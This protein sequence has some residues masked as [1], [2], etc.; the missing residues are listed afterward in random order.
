MA[1]DRLMV[2]VSGVRG[3]IGTTLTPEVACAF[4][5]AFGTML[6]PGSK[7][8][9]A[10]DSRPSGQ[11]VRA[12]LAAGLTGCGVSVI[13]LGVVTTP[14]AALMT[15]QLGCEGGIVVTASHNPAQYNGFK[16]L[17][18]TGPCLRAPDAQRLADIWRAGQFHTVPSQDC[19]S[20]I[21]NA[22]TH[23]QH[24]AAVC[25]ILDVPAIAKRRFKV[26]LDSINGAGC[27]GTPR[28][29]EAL[30]AELIHLNGQATGY[31]A[32]TPE[33]IAENLTGLC[34]AVREHGADVG[35]A[36][37][38]D[39][40]RLVVVDEKGQ[41]IG[42]EYT[43]AMT[44][45]WTLTHRKGDLATNLATS[46]MIDDIASRHGVRVHRS[47]TG[48]ANVVALMEARNC[49]FGGEGNGGVIDPRVVC[50]R[51]SFTGIGMI[52]AHLAE[53]GKPLSA[54]V[55]D[56]PAYA[57]IKTKMP[58]PLAAVPAILAAARDTYAD[59]PDATINDADG[60]RIDLPGQWVA[61]RA[62]NTEPIIRIF[63]ESARAE[64]ARKL[65][66]ELRSQAEA[67]IAKTR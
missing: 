35:F 47:P 55:A 44:A 8:T 59:H 38:P 40:D 67:I 64:D 46:R 37:D 61:V 30:G 22:G 34:A 1:E 13:D 43:L 11:M 24:V 19:G 14:G 50:V 31:F 28:L 7:V 57:L 42:E 9:M 6:G 53:S 63:A 36:Q 52:L 60:I 2:G 49:I 54:L 56:I 66:D 18:P 32:H 17:Q 10:R 15:N 3:T 58:C 27:I 39:A 25:D 33:P 4:G 21:T 26:V 23:E 12:A 62:S 20:V 29:L 16:F 48:E 65:V 45:A 5:C 51:D 41:F